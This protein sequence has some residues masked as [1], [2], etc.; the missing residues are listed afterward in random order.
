MGS[1]VHRTGSSTAPVS[2]QE[3]KTEQNLG[4]SAACFWV[5]LYRN[6]LRKTSTKEG[7]LQLEDAPLHFGLLLLSLKRQRGSAQEEQG[8]A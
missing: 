3:H 2:S 4:F 1:R 6:S 7:L 8:A 5:L